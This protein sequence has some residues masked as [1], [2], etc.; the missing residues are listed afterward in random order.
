VL[1]LPIV[2]GIG[3]GL[4]LAV[5]L[6]PVFF[7]LIQTSI[8]KGFTAGAYMAVGIVLSDATCI[9]ISY[10][11]LLQFIQQPGTLRIIGIFG[12]VFMLGYGTFLMLNKRV[13]AHSPENPIEKNMRLKGGSLL[14]G[15]VLNILNPFAIIYWLGVSSLVSA[16]PDFGRADKGLFFAGTLGTVLVTDLLKSYGAKKLRRF[17]TRTVILWLN[18]ISGFVLMVFGLKILFDVFVLEKT[19][20]LN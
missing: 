4:V 2:Q 17:V 19:F 12:G 8:T 5:L 11:G 9:L 18:R 20:L 15:F 13:V 7:A 10:F 6:G 1:E 16:I 3:F 14:K